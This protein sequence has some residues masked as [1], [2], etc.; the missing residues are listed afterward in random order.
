M[1]NNK[2]SREKSP[3][4][5]ST[6]G[7]TFESEE[8]Q[9]SGGTLVFL[10]RPELAKI[11]SNILFWPKPSEELGKTWPSSNIKDKERIQ[12]AS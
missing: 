11:F 4:S 2:D 12:V 7:R 5:D 8:L 1:R 10:G 9:P 3:I 6:D